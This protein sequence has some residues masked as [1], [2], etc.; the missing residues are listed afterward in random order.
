MLIVNVKSI[1][2]LGMGGRSSRQ[3]GEQLLYDVR[4]EVPVK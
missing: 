3:R 4:D 2:S 1:D